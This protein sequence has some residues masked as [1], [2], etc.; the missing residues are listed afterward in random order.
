MVWRWEDRFTTKDFCQSYLGWTDKDVVFKDNTAEVYMDDGRRYILTLTPAAPELSEFGLELG[1]EVRFRD[2][3]G[4]NFKIGKV[5]RTNVDGSIE[6]VQVS[7]GFY[8]SI[9]PELIERK[10]V[11]PRG[12][13][14]WESL[15]TG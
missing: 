10:V 6:L 9:Y 8:R 11:G 12:G 14:N 15:A 4:G 7:T 3:P 1:D 2:K 5:K 13:E